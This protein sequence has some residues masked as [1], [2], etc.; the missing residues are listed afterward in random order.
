M[1]IWYRNITIDELNLRGKH[2]LCDFLHIRFIEVGDN[3][4]KATMPADERT[5][6]PI[7]IVHGGANVVLAETIASTAANAVIDIET[8]YCVG[9]EINAN[10][11]RAVRDGMITAVTQPIHLGRS[12]QV[13]HIDLFDDQGRKTCVSRMTASILSRS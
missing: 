4:L 12:T 9:L 13:W 2:S 7:G 3:F 11:L 5:K 6:Q 10:H 1:S 8:M